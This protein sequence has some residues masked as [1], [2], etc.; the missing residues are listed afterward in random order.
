LASSD[1]AACGNCT[2]FELLGLPPSFKIDVKEVEKKFKALQMELHPDKFAHASPDEQKIS[3]EN[4]ARLNEAFATLKS[5]MLRAK[6]LLEAKGV[7]AFSE[8]AKTETD[9]AIL[10]EAMELR[11]ELDQNTKPEALERFSKQVSERVKAVELE[12]AAALGDTQ[13]LA[14]AVTL[15]VR[16][17][18]LEKILEEV[19]NK[20]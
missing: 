3:T 5:P 11:E 18:Y 1:K 16:L 2:H 4:S 9:M 14:Y 7:T 10:T 20:M 19:K 13:Q 8:G 17:R 15:A 12:L 6:Y